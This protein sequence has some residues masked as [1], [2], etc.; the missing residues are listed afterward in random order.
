MPTQLR[1]MRPPVLRPTLQRAERVPFQVAGGADLAV[2]TMTDGSFP[3]ESK[4]LRDCCRTLVILYQAG[5]HTA[6]QLAVGLLI[7]YVHSHGTP[8]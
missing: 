3:S 5:S 7:R 2:T 8:Y 4:L 1:Q 6:M